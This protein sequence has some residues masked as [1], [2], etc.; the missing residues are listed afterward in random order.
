MAQISFGSAVSNAKRLWAIHVNF[1]SNGTSTDAQ[2]FVSKHVATEVMRA[3]G[4]GVF[5]IGFN[6]RVYQVRLIS[7]LSIT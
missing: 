4:P 7:L 1:I 3:C 5:Q 2:M 6:T